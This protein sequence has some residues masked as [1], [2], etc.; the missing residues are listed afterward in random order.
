MD[1]WIEKAV[2]VRDSACYNG[3]TRNENICDALCVYSCK[4]EACNTEI[5][6]HVC[7]LVRNL[8]H[9]C[10]QGCVFPDKKL[11]YFNYETNN[12]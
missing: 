2:K 7:Q 9:A 8:I 11:L 5:M 1:G 12:H 10:N 3:E 4:Y 6:A